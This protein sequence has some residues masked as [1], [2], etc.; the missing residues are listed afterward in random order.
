[1]CVCVCGHRKHT[2]TPTKELFC[3]FVCMYVCAYVV[4]VWPS[5]AYDNTHK[6]TVVFGCFYVCMYVCMYVWPSKAYDDTHKRT[7]VQVCM[8]VCI[9]V[10]MCVCVCMCGHPKHMMTPVCVV[11]MLIYKYTSIHTHIGAPC[12]L[13]HLSK[14]Y[15][16]AYIHAY[17]HTHTHTYTHTYTH[18]HTYT[19][20]P[21]LR[22][23]Y[24]ALSVR[25]MHTCIHIHI[26]TCIHAQMYQD[27]IIN[28]VCIHADIYTCIHTYTDVPRIHDKFCVHIHTYIHGR[29]MYDAR[30]IMMQDIIYLASHNISS[31]TCRNHTSYS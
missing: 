29:I 2:I 27:F 12:I 4:C 21:R 24:F 28:F 3:L 1:M 26:H 7:V 30:Y 9:Y 13:T 22:G 5:E 23:K 17:I 20:A 16:H 14:L 19:D 31:T 6:R 18:T 15:I 8:Y 11:F 25:V 10:C